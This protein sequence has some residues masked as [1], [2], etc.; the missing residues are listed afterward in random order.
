MAAVEFGTGK[1]IFILAI[2]VGCFAVLW[3]KIF[4][5]ML[6]ASINVPVTMENSQGC[7]DVI[8]EKD[9][10]A[11]RIFSEMC[12]SVPGLK[13]GA[14]GKPDPKA[15]REEVLLICGIDIADVI[16]IDAKA[17]SLFGSAA[18][19]HRI[20][21]LRAYNTS[22]CLKRNFGLDPSTIGA[23]RRMRLGPAPP[24]P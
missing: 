19:R 22:L 13:V 2:V 10:N 24:T 5:P 17:S 11:Q 8:F 6:Q 23:P 14:D 16:R 21:N 1:T 3:P 4:Y 9:V 18:Y 12:G 7:C 20:Q 15:C